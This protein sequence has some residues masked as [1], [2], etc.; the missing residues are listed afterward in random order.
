MCRQCFLES[1]L[2]PTDWAQHND[3]EPEEDLPRTSSKYIDDRRSVLE[4][5]LELVTEWA[6]KNV[7]PK[8]RLEHRRIVFTP[9]TRAVP[10]HTERWAERVYTLLPRVH[11]PALL[12]E[13]DG[14][15]RLHASVHAPVQWAATER[16]LWFVVGDH[17]ARP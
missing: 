6:R 14:L 9:L 1:Y 7:L 15:D 13:V 2:V 5:D 12:Q 10:D 17:R 4:R 16:S 11:L 3:F 8:A